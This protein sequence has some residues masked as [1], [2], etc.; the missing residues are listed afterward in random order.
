MQNCRRKNS[1]RQVCRTI[2]MNSLVMS[3]APATGSPASAIEVGFR[4][5]YAGAHTSRTIMLT[6]LRATLD[7][8]PAGTSPAD[9]TDAIVGSNCLGKSTAANR[10]KT[11]QRLR[12]LY[13]LDPAVPL[14]RVLRRLWQ[15]D[16]PGRPLLALLAAIARDPLLMATAEAVIPMPEGSQ[17]QRIYMIQALKAIVADRFNDS[18]LDKVIRNAASSWTQ[19]GHLD[20]RTF[21]FR[22]RVQPTPATLAFALYLGNASGFHGEELLKSG[23][24]QVLDCDAASA[25]NL[26]MEA[27]RLG[28]IDLKMGGDVIEINTQ[29]LDPRVR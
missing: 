3:F 22:R 13:A 23:W 25:Q 6:E 17:F 14:F 26:A 24:V 18:T 8:V 21:K 12:E 9:Y 7:A 28:L 29:R 27:K 11:N 15:S 10:R 4:A 20:G 16:Q 2:I 19:S 5:D 1:V